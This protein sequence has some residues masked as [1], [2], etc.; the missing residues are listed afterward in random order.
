MHLPYRKEW[1]ER[2]VHPNPRPAKRFFLRFCRRECRFVPSHLS[3]LLGVFHF[4]SF[5]FFFHPAEAV[6]DFWGK[7]IVPAIPMTTWQFASGSLPVPF[8]RGIASRKE[9]ER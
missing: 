7:L 5:F 2:V 4:S 8:A 9:R 1:A 3:L 6:F